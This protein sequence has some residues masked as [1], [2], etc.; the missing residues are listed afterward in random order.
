MRG[1][2]RPL[3]IGDNSSVNLVFDDSHNVAAGHR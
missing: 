2:L 1:M 3:L